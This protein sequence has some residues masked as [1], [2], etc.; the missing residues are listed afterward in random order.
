[1][2]I[3]IHTLAI[4]FLFAC[5]FIFVCICMTHYT[6]I[7]RYRYRYTQGPEESMCS[8]VDSQVIF[9]DGLI[10][11][12]TWRLS[13]VL[14][15]IRGAGF[16]RRFPPVQLGPANATMSLVSVPTVVEARA[17]FH[18]QN[19]DGIPKEFSQWVTFRSG[20]F[21]VFPSSGLVL[22]LTIYIYILYV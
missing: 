21:I 6:H 10:S 16:L 19:R 17:T 20:H 7:H 11:L 18:F 5:R 8:H 22:C 14:C 4:T 15:R 13:E 3:H 12:D 1:M 2:I 9:A